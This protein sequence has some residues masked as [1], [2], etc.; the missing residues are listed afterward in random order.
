MEEW[1]KN[2]E[3][4]LTDEEGNFVLK[5]DGTPRLKGGRPKGSKGRGYNYHSQTKAKLTANRVIKDKQ[6][7]IAKTESKLHAY[8][9]SLKNTKQ[10][11]KKLENSD[12]DKITTPE[13]LSNTP[14]QVQQ[15]AKENVIF[16]P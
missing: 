5:K 8:K 10:T 15:E 13:E 7:K 9:E 14:K 11:I 6:K 2:P 3:N 16:A 1:E 12:S 4:Y